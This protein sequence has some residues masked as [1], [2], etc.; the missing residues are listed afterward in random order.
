M[1][2]FFTFLVPLYGSLPDDFPFLVFGDVAELGPRQAVVKVV[3][4]LVV[5][6]QAQQVAVLHVHQVVRLVQPFR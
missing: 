1:I 5:F 4:H 2:S 6:G 3:F